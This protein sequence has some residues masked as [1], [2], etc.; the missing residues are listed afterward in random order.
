MRR[1]GKLDELPRDLATHTVVDKYP[2]PVFECDARVP[3]P[4]Q[5]C[6]PVD[7]TP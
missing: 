5:G 1:Y 6:S 7:G 2:F 4:A 3:P